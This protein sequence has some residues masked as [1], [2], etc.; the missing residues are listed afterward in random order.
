MR[1]RRERAV[2]DRADEPSF[3]VHH[4]VQVDWGKGAA[5]AGTVT[6]IVSSLGDEATRLFVVYDNGDVGW[7]TAT[8]NGLVAV[9]PADAPAK[10]AVEKSLDDALRRTHDR[11]ALLDT[12]AG[13]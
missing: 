5:H 8:P 2:N 4:R 11:D 1:R 13:G 3:K 6:V 7:A 9:S 12:W 10:E